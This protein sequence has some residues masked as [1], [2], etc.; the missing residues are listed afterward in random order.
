MLGTSVFAWAI[1]R[2]RGWAPSLKRPKSQFVL[3][4]YSGASGG[5]SIADVAPLARVL[6]YQGHL[7]GN[8]AS[9]SQV[10]KEQDNEGKDECKAGNQNRGTHPC[11]GRRV[12]GS[13]C[14]A[15]CHRDGWRAAHPVQARNPE[16]PEHAAAELGK[17]KCW[18]PLR[19]SSVIKL[20]LSLSGTPSWSCRDK[21]NSRQ[22]YFLGPGARVLWS[23]CDNVILTGSNRMDE[24][25]CVPAGTQ[26]HHGMG[27]TI[28]S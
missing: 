4:F 12:R 2:K 13:Q 16:L 15:D 22:P 28:T 19:H 8:R 10:P 18:R 9:K 26:C 20:G 14:S 6:H 24:P 1:E 5:T 17:R 21:I 3:C 27:Y 7:R 11:N 23:K 25:S